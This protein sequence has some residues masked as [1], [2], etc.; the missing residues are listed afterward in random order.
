MRFAASP[1]AAAASR[2]AFRFR[3]CASPIHG[4]FLSCDGV[5]G[6]YNRSSPSIDWLI[7]CLDR[8]MDRSIGPD[9][10]AVVAY[11]Q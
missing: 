9:W 8:W 3:C 4:F 1:P 2:L 11:E 5:G 7:H 10:H 6:P